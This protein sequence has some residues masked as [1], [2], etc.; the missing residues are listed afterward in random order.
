MTRPIPRGWLT[1]ALLATGGLWAWDCWHHQ[2]SWASAAVLFAWLAARKHCP[3]RLVAVVACLSPFVVVPVHVVVA[4][5]ASYARGDATLARAA[6]GLPGPESRNLDPTYRVFPNGGRCALDT[7]TWATELI[8]RGTLIALLR[9]LGP[10]KGSYLGPYPTAS[11]ADTIVNSSG[12][13]IDVDSWD[14]GELV[15]AGHPLRVERRW[16]DQVG[17]LAP[18]RI[19]AGT[20]ANVAVVQVETDSARWVFLTD[21]GNAGW[22]ATYRSER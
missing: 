19:V 8:E 14:D 18:R 10:M 6:A 5:A 7:G 3:R 16:R 20:Q 11:E 9:A 21:L 12:R 15:I 17:R 1:T 2:A 4:T 22:F 13:E